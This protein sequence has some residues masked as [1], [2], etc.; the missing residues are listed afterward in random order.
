VLILKEFAGESFVSV[1]SNEVIS[2]LFA[3]PTRGLG[4]VDFKWVRDEFCL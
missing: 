4:S 2:P 1:D 3:T